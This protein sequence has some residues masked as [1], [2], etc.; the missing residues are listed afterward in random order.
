MKNP[1]IRFIFAIVFAA[2]AVAANAQ[3]TVILVR[4]AELQGAAM[5]GPK[6]VPL[7]EAGEARAKRLAEMLKDSGIGAIYVTD[8]E[9]TKKTAEPLAREL[10]EQLTVLPKLDPL[11]LVA[12]LRRDHDGQT[13][14]LVGHTDT[15]PGLL[16][17]MGHPVD[18]RIEPDDYGNLF[19]VVSK[20]TGAPSFL[21]LRY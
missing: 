2:S 14:L 1:F 4:H 7:S 9:R 16:K 3:Q 21:H 15:L 6:L 8:F 17:A 12:R 19:V 10:N 5:A 13:V 20:D 18:V 11:V